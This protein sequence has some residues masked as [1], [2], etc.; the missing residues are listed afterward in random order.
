MACGETWKIQNYVIPSEMLS[1]KLSRITLKMSDLDE[2]D[3]AKEKK[4]RGS[5]SLKMDVSEGPRQKPLR[6]LEDLPPMA[7]SVRAST[8]EN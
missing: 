8:P 6:T 5:K 3:Q 2:F 7:R 4:D 1:Q